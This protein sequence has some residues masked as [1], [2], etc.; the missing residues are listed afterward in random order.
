MIEQYGGGC[1][2][3]AY[4][5]DQMPRLELERALRNRGFVRIEDEELFFVSL[6]MR[7]PPLP[8]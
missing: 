1:F 7:R 6:E 3:A 5:R 4:Y 8:E 2:G